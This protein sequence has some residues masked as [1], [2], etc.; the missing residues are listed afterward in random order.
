MQFAL[1]GL[2]YKTASLELREKVHFTE[3]QKVE[4]QDRLRSLGIQEAVI[5]GTCNRTEIYFMA[6]ADE[7][8]SLVRGFLESTFQI[9]LGHEVINAYMGRDAL[10]YLYRVCLGLESQVVGEDQILGQVKDAHQDAM[11]LGSCGK[12]LNRI[13]RSA[14][15]FAKRIKTKTGASDI[16]TSVAYLG[17]ACL[18]QATGL[19][20]AKVLLIGL[21]NMGQ[22]ALTYL[23]EG[24]AHVY[25]ANR[26]HQNSLKLKESHPE[27]RLVPYEKLT[28]W[29]PA[30]DGVVTA[31]AS[32]HVILTKS[33][34]PRRDKPL[35]I[36]DLSLPRDVDPDVAQLDQ[37]TLLDLDSLELLS[38]EHLAKKRQLLESQLRDLDAELTELMAWLAGTKLDVLFQ[39]AEERCQCIADQTIAYLY[40]KTDLKEAEKKKVDKI[41]RSAVKKAMQE[42]L[43]AVRE[44]PES[45]Q[46]AAC[47]EFL[48]EILVYGAPEGE[49]KER[50]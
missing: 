12:L 9:S 43:T 6:E 42:T 25:V 7:D 35:T 29:L 46:K 48:K 2:N 20:D 33:D 23:L 16:P 31:T 28:E 19:K 1:V 17:I 8:L 45:E 27:V 21:G 14:V 26:T 36:V 30:M 13:F 49:E 10:N 11:D 34:F 15:T 40:R 44:Q 3:S 37:V 50:A 41:V 39:S 32:P 47:V 5:L 38:D 18:K 4:A 22:L 24:G